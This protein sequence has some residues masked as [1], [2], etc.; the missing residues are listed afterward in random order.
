[1]TFSEFKNNF[2]LILRDWQ[3]KRVSIPLDASITASSIATDRVIEKGLS[4]SGSV[5]GKYA[6]S[7]QKRK[8]KKGRNRG[9]FP[10]ITFQDTNTMW[11]TTKPV[12]SK[13][14]SDEV[15]ISILP[16]DKSRQKIMG[17]HNERFKDKGKLASL[18]KTELKNLF[19]DYQEELDNLFN[20]YL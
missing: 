20:R 11:R 13:V 16:S 17:I 14:T 8:I 10:N 7:T 15:V 9:V 5:F 2:S 12:V 19:D 1:M 18:N 4:S 6:E 3:N